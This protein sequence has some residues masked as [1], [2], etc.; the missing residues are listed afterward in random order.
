MENFK[1]VTDVGAD[2]PKDFLKEHNIG[3]L[4]LTYLLDGVQ[5]TEHN[6]LAEDV[7]YA[8][9]RGGAMPTTSQVNP[10]DAKEH[11]EK[12]LEENK[13]ILYIAKSR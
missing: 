11:F 10:E 3:C 9:M 13:N 4:Y 8:K 2:L 5:Y 6:E 1:I 12:Y 7:F